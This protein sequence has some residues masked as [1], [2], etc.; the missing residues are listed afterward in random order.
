MIPVSD[1]DEIGQLYD[2]T[3]T[4]P[5]R[6]YLEV[7]TVLDLLGDLTGKSVLD[8]GSGSG[9]YCAQLARKGARRVVGLDVSS[10]MVDYARKH[11]AHPRIEYLLGDLP[12]ELRGHFDAVLSVYVFGYATTREQLDG[13]F[14][15]AAA[16]LRPGGRFLVLGLH[17]DHH[18]DPDYYAPY[19]FR[20]RSAR[21]RVDG[22]LLTLEVRFGEHHASLPVTY[23]SREALAAALCGAGFPELTQPGYQLDARGRQEL[24]I[25]FWH[26]Y[27]ARPHAII[28]ESRLS[29]P[30]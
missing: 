15:T 30:E 14:R 18:D 5:W 23:W 29:T 1:F 16:A 7:P 2:D 17:P 10:G 27:L 8:L 25:E 4:L 21:S 6:R 24:G 12:D 26:A 19:G 9:W 22:S 11:N 20:L 3:F 13:L 28:L